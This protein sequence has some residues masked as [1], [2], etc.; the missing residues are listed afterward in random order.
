MDDALNTVDMQA[1]RGDIGPYEDIGAPVFELGER[2]ITLSLGTVAMNC[3]RSKAS[4]AE[5]AREAVGAMLGSAEDD[6]R[7]MGRDERDRQ[8]RAL[9][10]NRSPKLV[11]P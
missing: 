7:G 5:L 4:L 10:A 3:N 6:R 1:P 2:T 9:L 8:A 11:R